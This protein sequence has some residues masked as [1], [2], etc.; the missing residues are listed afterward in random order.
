MRPSFDV[1][2]VIL[3]MVSLHSNGNPKTPSKCE[4]PKLHP[5]L[6]DFKILGM[7][8]SWTMYSFMILSKLFSYI[9]SIFSYV[10]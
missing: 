4:R 6:L 10:A 5:F 7:R 8:T 2:E 3:I 9:A 1:S